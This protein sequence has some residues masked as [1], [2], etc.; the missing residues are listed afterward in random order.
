MK[1]IDKNNFFYLISYPRSGNTWLTMTLSD[2]LNIYKTEMGNNQRVDGQ[3]L[4]FGIFTSKLYGIKNHITD[5]NKICVKVHFDLDTNFEEYNNKFIYLIRDPRDV[6]ISYYFYVNSNRK[7]I[8]IE[9]NELE[10]LEFMRKELPLWKLHIATWIK[11]DGFK[12]KYEDLYNNFT[13]KLKEIQKY[14]DTNPIC[15]VKEV[16]LKHRL[17]PL[18]IENNNQAFCRKGQI[19]D[20]KNYFNKQH[21]E[22][23]LSE[24]GDLMEE[25]GYTS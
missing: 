19:G 14:L 6:M 20:H 1:K 9:F 16:E 22:Y 25:L 7:K 3:E 13:D 4:D 17:N 21:F 24:V 2:Y 11:R 18:Y 12:L 10:F 8:D 15:N 23:T 5:N